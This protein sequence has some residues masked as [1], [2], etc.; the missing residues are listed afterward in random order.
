MFLQRFLQGPLNP[1][2]P[3]RFSVSILSTHV[4]HVSLL[5][6]CT[7]Q[8]AHMSVPSPSLGASSSA[9]S[10]A[11]PEKERYLRT[12]GQQEPRRIIQEYA[13]AGSKQRLA[14]VFPTSVTPTIW[15]HHGSKER[16]TT[17]LR[18]LILKMQETHLSSQ[19]WNCSPKT[20]SQL[21]CLVFCVPARMRCKSSTIDPLDKT[22]GYLQTP[23]CLAIRPGHKAK[24]PLLKIPSFSRY[25]WETLAFLGK[26]LLFW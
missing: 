12:R 26:Y 24:Y 19:S 11:G 13:L 23:C 20:R 17:T 14:L 5:K 9:G 7:K 25:F 18:Q 6:T 4:T 2:P 16:D 15:R 3:P 22:W 21:A 8:W 10:S 1:P